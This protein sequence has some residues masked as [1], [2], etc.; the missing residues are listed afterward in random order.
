[1]ATWTK[2]SQSQTALTL[3]KVLGKT[4][5]SFTSSAR[6]K[7]TNTYMSK[8]SEL[9]NRIA[10]RNITASELAKEIDNIRRPLESIRTQLYTVQKNLASLG[11]TASD[12]KKAL[13]A[14]RAAITVIKLLPLP[15]R[16]LVVAVTTVYS[17]TLET[18]SEKAAQ[19]E[20]IA[21]SLIA[22]EKSLSSILESIIQY[23]E[24]ILRLLD[25]LKIL[26]AVQDS[27]EKIEAEL[28]ISRGTYETENVDNYK[29]QEN[30]QTLIDTGFIDKDNTLNPFLD[31]FKDL[32]V[33][34][35]SDTSDKIYT[36]GLNK[37]NKLQN[38]GLGI[39]LKEQLEG[40]LNVVET[41]TEPSNVAYYTAGDGQ[42]LT[43]SVV[44]D[45]K[46]PKIA[47][48]RYVV[49]RDESNVVVYEGTKTFAENTEI[50][51]EETKARLV[52]L[53]G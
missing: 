17:D 24:N 39:E 29:L 6:D 2:I 12:V 23:I 18:L 25:L 37:L 42:V 44:V 14:L 10:E 20:E 16:W 38:S 19:I 1:M 13:S 34:S 35:D 33:Y 50:L 47:P 40:T 5:G 4:V 9:E 7:L 43:L 48:R 22:T 46:S 30:L 49:A 53:F 51:I 31:T 8:I 11:K 45:P 41:P 52:Q 27:V 32:T 36:E 21:N 28:D 26:D 15:Q 3:G